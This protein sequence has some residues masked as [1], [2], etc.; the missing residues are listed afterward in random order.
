[1][2]PFVV[3]ALPRTRSFWLSRFL[4]YGDVVCG[5][6]ELRHC[7]SLADVRSW[8]AQPLAG[9][10]ETSA[11]PFWRL[12]ERVCSEARVV[13][14]RRPVAA[15][16]ASLA[17]AGLVFDERVMRV[18]MWRIERKLDQIERRLPG[19]LRTTYDELGTEEGCARVFQ[20]CLGLPHDHAWWQ[21]VAPLNLQESVPHHVRYFN[22]H[23]KQ[24]EAF[25]RIARHEV[26]RGLQRPVELDG[27]VFQQE[28]L[29]ALQCDGVPLMRDEA[30]AFGGYPEAWEHA[31]MPLLE[32]M[33]E[34]GALHIMT[35]RSNGRMFGYCMS[36][37]GESFHV[38]G[39]S[40]AEQLMF[41][42]DPRWPGL[43]R[44]LQHASIDDLRA[45]GIDRVL[46]FQPDSTRVGMVYRRLGAQQTGQR[47]VLE[48]Q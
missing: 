21:A 18:L 24:V 26:L 29:A 48:L 1:M 17:R 37:I 33:E 20:H 27:V 6:D 39:Q 5:H 35:A 40:E 11:A 43:G 7:R 45:R 23:A 31:N 38:L 30:V 14:L 10:V 36:A 12:L 9:S 13:T 22:A 19:V 44:K 25:R 2:T 42:A 3:F 46:M 8:L 47:Y 34:N 15:V 41:F 4:S 32:R 28:P 16:V